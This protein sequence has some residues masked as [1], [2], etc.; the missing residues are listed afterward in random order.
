MT[1]R[2]RLV[3]ANTNGG[4]VEKRKQCRPRETDGGR[5]VVVVVYLNM[6]LHFKKSVFADRVKGGGEKD[7][8][9]IITAHAIF[10]SKDDF[11]PVRDGCGGRYIL[12]T[13]VDNSVRPVL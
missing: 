7:M 4:R 6:S 10:V 3:W 12:R 1:R 8:H 5:R 11:A 2:N 13:A 9:S